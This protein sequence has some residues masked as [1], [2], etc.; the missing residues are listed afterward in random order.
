MR[1]DPRDLPLLCFAWKNKIY[2]DSAVP[3]GLCHGARNMQAIS[4]AFCQILAHNEIQTLAY[5]DN[6]VGV[7]DSLEKAREDFQT[8]TNLLEQ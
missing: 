3:F 5:I 6:I 1:S 2:V 4:Q 7:A 8:A